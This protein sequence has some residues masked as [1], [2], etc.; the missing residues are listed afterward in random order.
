VGRVAMNTT[1]AAYRR[2]G[3]GVPDVLHGREGTRP[4]RQRLLAG[5]V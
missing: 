2:P 5:L 1:L 4:A 3:R